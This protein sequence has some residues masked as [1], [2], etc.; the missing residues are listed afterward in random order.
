[1]DILGQKHLE[2]EELCAGGYAGMELKAA[3]AAE[4]FPQKQ[5]P[6]WG[7]CIRESGS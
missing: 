4:G 1:M 3:A 6:F 7:E 2:K 5:K